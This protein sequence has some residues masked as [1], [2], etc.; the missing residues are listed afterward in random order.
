MIP[1]AGAFLI[2]PFRESNRPLFESLIAV[3]AVTT[4]VYV[5]RWYLQKVGNVNFKEA[6][7]VGITWLVMSVALDSL[8][9]LFGPFK[10]SLGEYIS[11]IG[12]TYLL[13]PFVTSAFRKA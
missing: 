11:D 3:I 4:L 13:F 1:F 10:M 7:Q 2:F 8:F 6:I 9:F 5:W 12:A